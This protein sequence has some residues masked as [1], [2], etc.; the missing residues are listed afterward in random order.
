MAPPNGP[1][2]QARLELD[3]QTVAVPARDV[4]HAPPLEHLVLHDDV[5]QHLRSQA[6]PVQSRTHNCRGLPEERVGSGQGL[7]W[8]KVTVS[9]LWDVAVCL[10][11]RKTPHDTCPDICSTFQQRI[12]LQSTD[13][14]RPRY[15]D[16]KPCADAPPQ[17]RTPAATH[18]PDL[19]PPHLV[20]GVAN[21][22]VAVGVRRPVMQGERL[23]RCRVLQ[24]LIHPL[25]RPP[26]LPRGKSQSRCEHLALLGTS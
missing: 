20:Q 13:R 10:V 16:P 12:L 8:R 5:L 15:P 19:R 25:L 6:S 22:E 3:G 24:R 17:P 26:G 14:P 11:S 9:G 7:P 2:G 1:S 18:K 4:L 23:P 21:V